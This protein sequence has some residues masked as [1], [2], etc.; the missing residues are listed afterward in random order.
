MNE[1]KPTVRSWAEREIEIAMKRIAERTAGDTCYDRGCYESALKAYKSLCEDG[2]S[3][4]SFSATVGILDRL[5]HDMPLSPITDED[6]PK[7]GTRMTGRIRTIGERRM[8]EES[9]QCPRM[10]GL[11]KSIWEDGK[12][13]YH[14]IN[15]VAC[16]NSE[17]INDTF[18]WGLASEII[19]ERYPITIPYYPPTKNTY[20]VY[21]TQFTVENNDVWS[22]DKF[23]EPSGNTVEV[24]RYFKYIGDNIV[25]IDKEEFMELK[26][27]RDV[28]VETQY[29]SYIINDLTE[30]NEDKN[31]SELAQKYGKLWCG[32]PESENNK[33]VLRDIW[34]MLMSKYRN[35][36][37]D[38]FDLLEK[39]CGVF[40]GHELA[41]WS[42][43]S[44]LTSPVESDGTTFVD[45]HP[46]FNELLTVINEARKM[47]TDK[48]NPYLEQ[49]EQYGA[50]VVEANG[51]SNELT[52]GGRDTI[53]DIIKELDP[54]RFRRIEDINA[55]KRCDETEMDCGCS[56]G[57]DC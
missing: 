38:M 54:D 53:R 41:G 5:C 19:D 55:E 10:S 9:I 15:R 20:F 48:I 35:N 8:N 49:M 11:F 42:T 36:M 32:D 56:C 40:I 17:N 37:D 1:E 21:V 28:S 51:E 43:V 45:K 23:K 24:N 29:T 25:E 50:K 31:E 33:Y 27:H 30:Y 18:H 4:F 22:F 26:A 44:R 2:H 46:E 12:V 6:F 47:V 39:H 52:P 7:Y 57:Y 13:T 14:D 3:G 34:W 16:V